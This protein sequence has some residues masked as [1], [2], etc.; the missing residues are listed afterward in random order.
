MYITVPI[1][2]DT[3]MN[4]LRPYLQ[5]CVYVWGVINIAG[6]TQS[7]SFLLVVS[8]E[9]YVKQF[10]SSKGAHGLD[11]GCLR[12]TSSLPCGYAINMHKEGPPDRRIIGSIFM[13]CAIG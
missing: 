10:V 1:I 7:S 13:A 4:L 6:E 12:P 2:I 3:Y 11:M 5:H 9:I 8:E